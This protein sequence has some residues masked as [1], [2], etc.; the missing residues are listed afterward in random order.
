MPPRKT[1][2]A[3]QQDLRSLEQRLLK[4]SAEHKDEIIRHF[5]VAVEAIQ[6]DLLGA[7]A[8]ELSLLTDR[9]TRI[10][11]RVGLTPA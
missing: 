8:D 6:H 7:N 11:N 4:A 3:T 5:D 2:Q 9:V 1:A 10:E